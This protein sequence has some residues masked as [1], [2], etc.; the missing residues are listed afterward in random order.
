MPAKPPQL[1]EYETVLAL[2]TANPR[3]WLGVSELAALFRLPVVYITAASTAKDTPFVGK[4]C[5]P[6]LLDTWLRN[7]PGLTAQ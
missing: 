1:S 6:D 3:A 5:H 7:H 2:V 4:S